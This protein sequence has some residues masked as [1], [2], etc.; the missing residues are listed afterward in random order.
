MRIA[1]LCV[2]LVACGLENDFSSPDQTDYFYQADNN[3]VD[4]LW[5]V[6]DSCSMSEEQQTLA[7]GFATFIVAMEDSGT[8]FQIGVTTTDTISETAGELLGSPPYVTPADDYRALFRE[9]AM[10]GIVG[11]DKE[12]GLQAAVNAVSPALADANAGFVRDTAQLMVI[13]VTDEEDC[14]DNGALDG[15]DATD[16]YRKPELL[17]PVE[18][19]VDLVK[20]VKDMPDMVQI[21]GII[22]NT[23]CEI[24]WPGYRYV[25][26]AKQ[27]AG[28]IGDICE[29]D[30]S[31]LLFDLGNNASGIRQKFQLTKAVMDGTLK[32]FVDEEEMD[33]SPVTGWT[34]DAATWY[35][36][37]HNQAIPE[38]GAE[39]RAEYTVGPGGRPQ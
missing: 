36:T 38:R 19:F 34:Y 8:D 5:I 12:K 29:D 24:A 37:F 3:E 18:D 22:G 23:H 14:S 27:T 16:C 26:A 2:F 6:D 20:A 28:V 30:W 13:V 25:E 31:D 21:S 32:V 39:I 10:V 35:V 33:E 15:M 1:F 11:P 4:I 7:N 17:P 9:R